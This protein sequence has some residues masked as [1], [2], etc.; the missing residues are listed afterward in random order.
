MSPER[1]IGD[2]RRRILPVDLDRRAGLERRRSAERREGASG[3]IRNA[4]QV[5]TAI[6]SGDLAP[7]DRERAVQAAAN[8]LWLALLEV[9]RIVEGQ[10][11][12]GAQLR[13]YKADT[14]G[15]DV[16]ASA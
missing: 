5:L 2:R 7:A 3:H 4:L 16:A 1:R 15:D 13:R 14:N 9:E 10:R 8:R 11:L 6:T 12:M